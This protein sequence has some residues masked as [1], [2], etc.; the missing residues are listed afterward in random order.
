M[1]PKHIHALYDHSVEW[2]LFNGAL[3]K[4][5]GKPV[6]NTKGINKHKHQDNK[7]FKQIGVIDNF[8]RSILTYLCFDSFRDKLLP[9]AIRMVMGLS[10]SIDIHQLVVINVSKNTN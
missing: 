7:Q 4:N 6:N 2:Q 1:N 8:K 10:T 5:V 9:T 3:S